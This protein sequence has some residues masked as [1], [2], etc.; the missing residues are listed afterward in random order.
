MHHEGTK[1][2]GS[3][4]LYFDV[5]NENDTFIYRFLDVY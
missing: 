3:C 5:H 1:Y 4:I 2:V